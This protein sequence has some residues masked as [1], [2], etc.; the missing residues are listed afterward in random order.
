LQSPDPAESPSGDSQALTEEQKIADTL[1]RLVRAIGRGAYDDGYRFYRNLYQYGSRAVPE[2]VSYLEAQDWS[3][4]DDSFPLAVFSTLV[5][6]VHDIDEKWSESLAALLSK[7]SMHERYQSRIRSIRSF[8]VEDYEQSEIRGIRVLVS[9]KLDKYHRIKPC[10]ERWFGNVPERDIASLERLYV[11]PWEE[12]NDYTGHY[13]PILHN[14]TIVWYDILEPTNFFCRFFEIV[15]E[16]VLYHEIGHH[17][18]RHTWGQ[19]P[20]QENEADAYARRRFR[21]AHPVIA[22]AFWCLARIVPRGLR[23]RLCKP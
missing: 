4:F 8:T 7:T 23:R 10:L 14:I 16:D 20:E 15:T 6:L 18:H 12:K 21:K 13:T 2:V 19:Q 17:A 9:K 3:R 1:N 11:V 22:S 5:S